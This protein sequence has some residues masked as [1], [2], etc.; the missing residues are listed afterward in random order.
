MSSSADDLEDYFLVDQDPRMKLVEKLNAN[1]SFYPAVDILRYLLKVLG[2][3]DTFIARMTSIEIYS[4]G[5]EEEDPDE[6][7]ENEEEDPDE[8]EENMEL[9]KA[10]LFL[11][12]G[13]LLL[14][15]QETMGI[16]SKMWE[17]TLDSTKEEAV[18][19]DDRNKMTF[20]LAVAFQCIEYS[21]QSIERVIISDCYKTKYTEAKQI[22]IEHDFAMTYSRIGDVRYYRQDCRRAIVSYNQSIELRSTI[23]GKDIKLLAMDHYRISICYETEYKESLD[24]CNSGQTVRRKAE[25]GDMAVVD[26]W[27]KLSAIDFL[28][29]T[30]V[31]S[32]KS[33]VAFARC[34]T[35]C[36]DGVEECDIVELNKALKEGKQVDSGHS[37]FYYQK[38]KDI[39]QLMNKWKPA[40]GF[41]S[42]F[43]II[44]QFV[45]ELSFRTMSCTWGGKG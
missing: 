41:E 38:M 21:Q 14:K 16:V 42:E 31:H 36:C 18:S 1:G 19:A 28:Y 11:L 30:M 27:D 3:S 24:A 33:A 35:G 15:D 13:D 32:F 12:I 17:Y 45:T 6:C 5:D 37:L 7:K 20:I 44:L 4:M 25:R 43:P 9:A 22:Q 26:E 34:L 10:K 29:F 2:V 39:E 40:P 23:T 8:C